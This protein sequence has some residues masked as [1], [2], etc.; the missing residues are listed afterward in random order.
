MEL[1]KKIKILAVILSLLLIII[2]FLAVL[3]FTDIINF[4]IAVILT[5]IF[6][7]FILPK[8]NKQINK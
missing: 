4:W 1:N 3:G 7:F 2:F 5:G 8:L 6:A